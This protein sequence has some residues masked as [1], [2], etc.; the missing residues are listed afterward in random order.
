MP[1]P[2]RSP[3]LCTIYLQRKPDPPSVTT[4]PRPCVS[5]SRSTQD[6]TTTT[7][8]RS[9]GTHGRTAQPEN[10]SASFRR[11][12]RSARR[13]S[14]TMRSL[15]G[16]PA[17]VFKEVTHENPRQNLLRHV[18][19]GPRPGRDLSSTIRGE[20]QRPRRDVDRRHGGGGDPGVAGGATRVV[21]IGAGG[22]EGR[23]APAARGRP[24]SRGQ[25]RVGAVQ[26]HPR[27]GEPCRRTGADGRSAAG[28]V[29]PRV[30]RGGN[31]ARHAVR[32]TR[33]PHRGRQERDRG[34]RS[35]AGRKH[36]A[37]RRA[38]ADS[39]SAQGVS[40]TR[41][42]GGGHAG[43]DCRQHV[44]VRCRR[45]GHLEAGA[46]TGETAAACQGCEAGHVSGGRAASSA[47]GF[48]RHCRTRGS[49]GSR[50]AGDA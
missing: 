30:P 5:G 19:K 7:L 21:P 34:V 40:E 25:H 11:F 36:H 45:A 4:Q 41:A 37:A 27:A 18:D 14:P 15:A 24:G 46:A 8:A 31:A 29:W 26:D 39:H 16:K 35:G 12:F 9:W 47:P 10:F 50:G 2:A 3:L 44:C 33:H 13:L 32:D 28:D 23:R 17:G 6:G 1:T 42:R 43:R 22:A 48:S 38:D 49:S 20:Q